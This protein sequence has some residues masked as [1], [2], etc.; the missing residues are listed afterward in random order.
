MVR[1]R[2]SLVSFSAQDDMSIIQPQKSPL[3]FEVFIHRNKVKKTLVDGGVGLNICTLNLVRALGYT[4]DFFDPRK[5]ITIKSYDDKER[6]SKGMFIL[7]IRV[8]PVVKEIVCQV[9][10]L[11]LTYNIL[12]VRLWIYDMQVIPSTY[13]QCLK[14]LYM[15][16]EVTT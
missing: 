15:G 11:Q 9:L 8:G 4:K 6:S 16:Q 10:D 2:P 5:K 14:F 1:N 13:H 3:Y 7:P 12:L